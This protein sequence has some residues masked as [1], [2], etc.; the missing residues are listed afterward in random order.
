MT[1]E[2]LQ[3]QLKIIVK[4]LSLFPE[5]ASSKTLEKAAGLKLS[6]RTFARRLAILEKKGK[7][8]SKGKT[9]NKR[10]FIVKT[11]KHVSA[12]SLIAPFTLSKAGKVVLS[13]IKKPLA[14]RKAVGYRRQ[15][16]DSYE[17]NKTSYLTQSETDK[18]NTMGKLPSSDLLQGTYGKNLISRVLIDLSFNSSRLE[19]NTYSLLDTQRLIELNETPENKT[20]LETYMV[21]NHKKA[22][23]YLARYPD[24]VDL[25]NYTILNLHGI[26]ANNLLPNPTAVGR[27]RTMPVG[28]GESVYDPPNIPQS[29]AELFELILQ[30]AQA[31]KNP[32]EQSFFIMVHLPYLQPFEDVNKRVSRLGANIPLI[33]NNLS[34]LS[35]IDVDNNLYISG[36]LGIYELNK[37]DLFKDLYLWAYERSCTRYANV[38]QTLG[39]PDTFRIKHYPAMHTLI[40]HIVTDNLTPKLASQ[41]IKNTANNIP[42]PEQ[43]KFIEMTET[44]LLSL[45]EGNYARYDI[46]PTEFK[47]WL[48]QW[49]STKNNKPPN[50]TSTKKK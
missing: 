19:G 5:G 31:I 26:L 21:L 18:L 14:E 8:A 42:K 11:E 34:P 29:I 1:E 15:F 13:A 23:E 40:Q 16:I 28:I 10:Y 25:N 47:V 32:F 46:R 33:K 30:K 2:N 37:I 36:M 41:A 43:A 44:E 38:R 4:A 22:I 35:F 3:K 9:Q 20:A 48:E 39:E 12:H 17:P 27:L 45:Y 24:E 7:I 49:L 6:Y 50:P